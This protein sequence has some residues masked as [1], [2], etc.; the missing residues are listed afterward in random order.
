MFI[1]LFSA[2]FVGAAVGALAERLGLTRNGYV[3]SIAIAVGGA[4][5]LTFSQVILG[6][7]LGFGRGMT[8]AV[9]AGAALFLASMRR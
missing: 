1:G 9:G 2:L 4:I 7:G 5:I 6:F 8:A 3:V